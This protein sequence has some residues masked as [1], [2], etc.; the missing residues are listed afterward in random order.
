MANVIQIKRSST[1]GSV[2]SAGA[3][4]AGE[5]ALNLTDKFLYAGTGSSVFQVVGAVQI[6]NNGT[7][8]STRPSINFIPGTNVT[9][10]VSD[11][12]V[13]NRA[14]VTI[15]A[16]SSATVT[17][18][19][20][21][22]GTTGLTTSGGPITTSGTITLGG[23]LGATSGGTGLGSFVSGGAVYATSTSALTTGTLPVTAGGTGV[24][25]ST[26]SGS[27]VL[28]NNG[29]IVTPSIR[30]MTATTSGTGSGITLAG[31]PV[32][33]TDAATKAYVDANAT[34]L[35]IHTPVTAAST[36]ALSAT[37][38]NGTSGVGATLTNSGAQA[39]FSL[40]GVSLSASQRVLIKDQAAAAQNGIYTVT[41]VGSGSTNWVLTR[42]T[43]F[44]QA[45]TGEVATGAYALVTSG[46]SN[47]N[48]SWVLNT[49]G[50]IT[51]GTTALNFVEFSSPITYSAGTGLTL[52]ANVFSITNTAVTPATYGSA[53][54]VPVFTVNGQGQLTGVTNTSIAIAGSQ[55]TSGTTGS[56]NVVFSTSPTLTT[57]NL[58]TPSSITLTNATGLSLTT[59]VAGTL[60][61]TN[62]GT[63]LTTFTSGGA[64][65][66]TSTSAL[67]TGTLPV[68][69]G[70]TGV[71]SSTGSGSVVL[72]TSP[73][74][75]TPALS[76]ETYSTSSA[77]TAST[78][79]TQGQTPLTSDFNFITTATASPS[80]VT[81]PTATVGRRVIVVNRGANPV[82]IYPALAAQI[83]ALGTNIAIQI[84]V[85]G[86]I[87]FDASST[88][89][90]Y[91]T[92]LL[93]LQGAT[94]SNASLS[95]GSVTNLTTF[96]GNTIN[97]GTY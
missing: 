53:S 48:T 79:N 54:S 22:G 8:N 40:D 19:Q 6:D 23:T 66:A 36:G 32:N 46:S 45:T 24:T 21:S 39:A 58:G 3:L 70:G 73:S 1:A 27:V 60:P 28:S 41:T 91:S 42:A 94:I 87:E 17:S 57:P 14:D 26:G 13:S 74:L 15:N 47:L 49:T 78:S 9:L 84:P 82:N 85:N 93:S 64:V 25:S 34:G 56:G 75:T 2:P 31:A 10:S 43:D 55:I 95:G 89:Q 59:G 18:V 83:D 77:I 96:D 67:T 20:V 90:W 11:N 4:Q 86:W 63:G 62:G 72:N 97:G 92:A 65:Y 68:T 5:M 52:A 35:Q 29:T 16:T 50:S 69:A 38:N 33:A 81:L 30:D 76:A 12:A 44:D 61:T 71:T 51:I 88:T 7:L 80:A 37:Y